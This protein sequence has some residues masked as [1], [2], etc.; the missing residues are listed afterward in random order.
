[1]VKDT[2]VYPRVIGIQVPG[3][4]GHISLRVYRVPSEFDE[5]EVGKGGASNESQPKLARTSVNFPIHSH[6]EE[7]EKLLVRLDGIESWGDKGVREKRR[8]AVK[9]VGKESAKLERCWKRAWIDHLEKKQREGMRVEEARTVGING[10]LGSKDL[11][12]DDDDEWFE[13]Q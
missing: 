8:L 7:L 4:E 3:K 9:E 11:D 10:E 5:A 2:F 1:M 13:V 12:D 6:K